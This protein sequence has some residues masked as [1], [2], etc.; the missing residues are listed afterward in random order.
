LDAHPQKR[1]LIVEDDL[2]IALTLGELVEELGHKV[3]GP[4]FT[5]EEGL[6]AVGDNAIDFALL[7]FDLGS[8]T[9]SIPIAQALM[10]LSV[11]FVFA[12][13]TDPKHMAASFAG[14]PVISKPVAPS[15]LRAALQ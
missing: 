11:P 9:D 5:L 13:G 15:E 6:A 14:H 1:V 2:L 7:D 12:T 3:I 4:A 10:L 8:D